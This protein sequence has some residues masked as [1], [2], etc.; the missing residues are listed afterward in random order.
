MKRIKIG[1]VLAAMAVMGMAFA[2]C[3][4]KESNT[5][6]STEAVSEV[7]TTTETEATTQEAVVEHEGVYN[8]L[9]G[10]WDADRT[11]PY[12]RPLAIMINNIEQS[13]PQAGVGDADVIYEFVVEGGITR[14]LAIYND[15][16]SIEKVGTIRSCRPYYVTTALEFDA[17]YVHFGQS[18][19]GQEEIDR[20]GIDHISGLSSYSS[21]AF[22]RSSDR[23]APHNV[24]ST[25]EMLKAGV[26]YIGCTTE[27]YNGYN[28]KFKF[29]EEDT[30]PSGESV[31]KLMLEMTYYTQ[32]WFEYD[33][34][35]KVYKRFQFGGAQIDELTG[36]QLT[37]KNIIIQFAHYTTLNEEDRQAIDL[38]GS[39]DGYYVSDGV[40]V[41]IT[42][43]KSSDTSIT[44]YYTEDGNELMLNPGKTYV[45]V[46][47]SDNVDKV[48]WE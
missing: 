16:E 43:R 44:K 29:N 24:Y 34:A 47:E 6:A 36:E 19:Q 40:L 22:Y 48:T 11:E 17:I 2:G 15:Y 26:D 14:L 33:S 37:F 46:F 31:N 9:T 25:G 27:H 1:A 42:W 41:P 5:E 32:P 8:D 23:E 13:L 20:T 18:T 4:S 10:E 12:G 30:A 28:G 7:I 38:I 3:G 21:I 35:N 45:T 39:G